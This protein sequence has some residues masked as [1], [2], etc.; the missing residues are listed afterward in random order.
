MLK[1]GEINVLRSSRQLAEM[2]PTLLLRG[3]SPR[4]IDEWQ[5]IPALWDSVRSE[6]DNRSD[7]GQFILTGSAV[8]I[9]SDEI[10]HTG[11]GRI[12]RLI[13]RPMSLFESGESTGEISLGNLF[14]EPDQIFAENRIDIE[15]LAFLVCR[16]GW[17]HASL[18]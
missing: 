9:D 16:G 4:L 12:G 10:E 1:L 2:D 6:V 5:T 7:L 18:L 15:Q 11:T 3:D 14:D 17:Q 8:P 13:M